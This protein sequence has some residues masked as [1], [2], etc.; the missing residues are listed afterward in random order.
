M[1]ELHCIDLETAPTTQTD[2]PYALE[3]YRVL[4]NESRITSLAYRNDEPL[5]RQLINV[6]DIHFAENVHTL[7]TAL[8]GKIVYCH[9]AIFDTGFMYAT[10]MKYVGHRKASD[11]MGK[12][13]WRDTAILYKYLINGEVATER[14]VSYS[15]KACIGRALKNHPL[16]DEFMDVKSGF[17]K[18]GVDDEYWL[19]RG[20]LDAH[21]TL[22]L[23]IYLEGKLT[24][25]MRP[26]YLAAC[27]AIWPLAEGWV[28]GIP[29]NRDRVEIY[30]EKSTKRMTDLVKEIGYPA[31]VFTSTKQLG[32]LLFSIL[33]LTPV[34]KTPKGAPS[35]DAES[36]L[37]LF[38]RNP[39]HPVL[40]PIM[41]FRKISTMMSKYIGGFDRAREYLGR[42]HTHASPRIL[43]TITGR[44]TYSSKILDT[45]QISIA[46]HQIPRK[47]KGIKQC[48]EAPKGYKVLYMDVSA[49]EGRFM[50]IIGPEPTMAN[51]YNN[52]ID[53]HSDLTQE[54]FGTA[55]Q[56]IV[57]ANN[58]GEPVH[59][60]EQRQA[61]KLTGLS[62]FYRI[63][64][65]ALARKF[66]STY[67]YDIEVS[68]AGSY[69]SAFKRKYPGVPRYWNRAINFA[70]RTGYAEAI[71]GWRYRIK[72]FDWKGESSAIN[73]PIQGSGAI[74]T[75]TTIGV[76]K[77][78]WPECILVAQVHDAIIYFIPEEGALE[79]ARDIKSTMDKFNYGKVLNF[80]QTVPII[81]DVSIGD[82]F[83]D[84]TNIT[85][86]KD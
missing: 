38:Q 18:P 2:L 82:N 61:G 81:L 16:Y 48:M 24:D 83:A 30:R 41:E 65:A 31:S 52:G 43:A 84:L 1:P 26:G 11:I 29:I 79:T 74:Q 58:S 19:R 53:T 21:L 23:A 51:A 69:L 7:L 17:H 68:T 63:G 72:T 28:T 73:H 15:L 75:Y 20:R 60:V 77:R 49:Q 34:K 47:D 46:Q 57:D 36:M 13:R 4:T 33:G 22:D 37:R 35:A 27:S 76:I 39:D 42:S 85:K 3:P 54:I 78:K 67:E 25:D 32:N 86:I 44:M 71:G 45:Y 10:I 8:E 66:F 9:N 62:S 6:D 64:A 40:K 59:I 70:K 56:D 80:E 12:V 14:K 5:Q 50:A 55:Y